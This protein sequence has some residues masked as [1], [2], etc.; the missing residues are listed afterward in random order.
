MVIIQK[1]KHLILCHM[2]KIRMQYN[3]TRDTAALRMA[4]KWRHRTLRSHSRS[5]S[6][7]GERER[8]RW[9]ERAQSVFRK[10]K[11]GA[12]DRVGVQVTKTGDLSGN[13]D[14]FSFS[15][16]FFFSL[17]FPP[18]FLRVSFFTCGCNIDFSFFWKE[19]S[20]ASGVFEKT[21]NFKKN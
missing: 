10:Q 14:S 17:F 4:L 19:K 8:G 20:F 16:D 18:H 6:T 11:S 13:P 9:G 21:K 2:V 1:Q 15:I 12:R 3:S 7:I 5:C